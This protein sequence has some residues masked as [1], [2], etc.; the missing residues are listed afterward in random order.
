[1][2]L[3]I[4]GRTLRIGRRDRKIFRKTASKRL[5]AQLAQ[6]GGSYK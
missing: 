1:M 2:S 6:R 4:G 3:K 5:K